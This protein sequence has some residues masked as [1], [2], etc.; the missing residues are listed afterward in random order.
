MRKLAPTRC[1]GV[2]LGLVLALPLLTSPRASNGQAVPAPDAYAVQWTE[3]FDAGLPIFVVSTPAAVVVAGA[4]TPAAGRSHDDGTVLWTS[5]ATTD[6]APAAA[7]GLVFL[8]SGQRFDVLDAATGAR[9]WSA[10]LR[11]P[12]ARTPGWVDGGVVVATRNGV[13]AFRT[14]GATA[15][16]AIDLPGIVTDPVVAGGAVF[17]GLES[18]HLVALAL[19]TGAERWRAV[20]PAPATGITAAD[21]RLFFA[22]LDGSWFAYAQ[23]DGRRLWQARARVGA[24]GRP[25]AGGEHVYLAFLDNTVQ[26]FDRSTGNRRWV[27]LLDDRPTAAPSLLGSNVV[28]PTPDGGLLA[29]TA[30]AAAPDARRLLAAPDDMTGATFQALA[31][32]AAAG[33]VYLLT[34]GTDAPGF[35]LTKAG[36]PAPAGGRGLAR[37]LISSAPMPRQP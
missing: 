33:G 35:R 1:W 27:A 28:L 29:V 14:T 34:S 3:R 25:V 22:T 16:W 8:A 17:V 26:A 6:V 10:A 37:R 2:G 7:E 21:S 15:V 23:S 5:D 19:A 18:G 24:V 36:P 11:H 4:D 9:R 20:L 32:D 31:V 13:E 12:V 30:G